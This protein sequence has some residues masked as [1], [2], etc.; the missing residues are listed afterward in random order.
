MRVSNP[1]GSCVLKAKV[2]QTVYPGLVMAQHGFWFPEE[3]GEEPHLYDVWR[4]NINLLMPHFYVG[5]LGFGAP[6]KCLICKVEP[7]EESHDT[8][9]QA[10]WNRYSQLATPE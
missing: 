4:S 9:M 3:D 6:Y 8:D 1:F 2:T 10:I 5:E 7:I